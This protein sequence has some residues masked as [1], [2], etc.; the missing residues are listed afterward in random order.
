MPYDQSRL[1]LRELAFRTVGRTAGSWFLIDNAMSHFGTGD[2]AHPIVLGR[3]LD[4]GFAVPC[5]ARSRRRRG[6]GI[7]HGP[8]SRL[9][10]A[11]C[12][13]DVPGRIVT[14]RRLTIESTAFAAGSFMCH[15]PDPSVVEQIIAACTRRHKRR[16]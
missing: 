2:G 12:R 15:E 13:I 16:R 5:L 4:T 9:H 10:T 8:H 6:S 7:R 1:D 11:W 14:G 3:D